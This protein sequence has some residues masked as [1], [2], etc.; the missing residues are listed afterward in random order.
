VP[1]GRRNLAVMSIDALLSL[2][3]NIG[4]ALS[5][6][7]AELTKQLKRLEPFSWSSR[8]GKAADG[9]RRS[10]GKLPPKYRDPDEPANVWAGRG[11]RPLWMQEK[12]KAGAKQEDFLIA[13]SDT[14]APRK[15]RPAKKPRQKTKKTKKTKGTK[16]TKRPSVRKRRRA[17]AA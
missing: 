12:I 11:A 14:P 2:R 9:R 17:P 7:S 10:G 13:T 15:K 8:G 6:R 5:K 3:E 1:K 4:Q 16:R